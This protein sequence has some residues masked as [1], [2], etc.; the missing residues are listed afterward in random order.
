MQNLGFLNKI[1]TLANQAADGRPTYKI[2][3]SINLGLF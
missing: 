1:T 3:L 2:Y